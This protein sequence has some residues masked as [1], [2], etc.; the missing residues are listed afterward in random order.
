MHGKSSRLDEEI[1]IVRQSLE[2]DPTN[3]ELANRYWATI[4]QG[5]YRSGRYVIDAYRE[6]A[7]TSST[8]AATLA[9]AYRELF[10][11]SGEAPYAHL[12]D[13]RLIEA[14]RSYV[15]Q[16]AEGDRINVQWV[17]PTIESKSRA[18][19]TDN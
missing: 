5:D 4:A 16:M 11:D 7:L 2:N 17:L 19:Q 18:T 13:E 6:V 1:A 10:L 3:I 15:P 8:G 12:F 9:R 14:L